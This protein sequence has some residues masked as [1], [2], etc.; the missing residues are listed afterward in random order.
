MRESG[1]LPVRARLLPMS[2]VRAVTDASGPYKLDMAETE[3]A[4]V[5][6]LGVQRG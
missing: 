4:E 1:R 6:S 3:C 2:Q 5:A